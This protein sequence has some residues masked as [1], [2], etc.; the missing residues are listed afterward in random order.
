MRPLLIAA[1]AGLLLIVVVLAV[2]RCAA[3]IDADY[4]DGLGSMDLRE[5]GQQPE[6]AGWPVERACCFGRHDGGDDDLEEK[7]DP[8]DEEYHNLPAGKP[9][10][11]AGTIDMSAFEELYRGPAA[12]P[13]HYWPPAVRRFANRQAGWSSLNRR[14]RRAA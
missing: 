14:G 10:R 12:F 11:Q 7:P 5:R 4:P 9:E 13:R 8:V 3:R 1:V 2:L 6:A